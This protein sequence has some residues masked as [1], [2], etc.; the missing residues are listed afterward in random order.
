MTFYKPDRVVALL[1]ALAGALIMIYLLAYSGVP[2]TSD[3]LWLMDV[4]GN[5]ALHGQSILSRSLYLAYT[6]NRVPPFEPLQPFLSAPLYFLSYQLPHIGNLQTLFLFNPLIAALIALVVFL[7]ARLLGYEERTALVAAVLLGGTTIIWPYTQTFFREPLTALTLILTAFSL[8]HARKGFA[9]NRLRSLEWFLLGFVFI[10][11]SAL[12]KEAALILLPIFILILVP[13]GIFSNRKRMAVFIGAV[14]VLCLL[15][16]AVFVIS[17]DSAAEITRRYRIF[18]KVT[19]L[20]N[21]LA[22]NWQQIPIHLASILVSPGK[23]FFWFSPVLVLSLISPRWLPASRWRESWLWLLGTLWFALIYVVYKIDIWFGGQSWGP[24]FLVP[25]VPLLILATLPALDKLLNTRR[26]KWRIVLI[27]LVIIGVIVQIAGVY[28]SWGD[29]YGYQQKQTGLLPWSDQINWSFRWSQIWGGLLHIPQAKTTILW[30]QQPIQWDVIILLVAS[31][32][33][34]S[35]LAWILHLQQNHARREFILAGYAA[36]ILAILVTAFVMIRAYPT[37][38]YQGDNTA[39]HEMRSYLETNALSQDRLLLSNH[40]YAGF[41]MNYYK[42]PAYLF[43][44]PDSPGEQPSPEQLPQIVSGNPDYLVTDNFHTVLTD[45]QRGG[46]DYEG[47]LIWLVSDTGQYLPWAI[48]PYEWY[49]ARHFYPIGVKEVDPRT[50]VASFLSFAAPEPTEGAAHPIEAL[51]GKAIGL[52]GY[53]LSNKVGID[54]ASFRPGDQLGLSLLW[55]PVNKI[56]ADYTLAIHIINIQGQVVVQQDIQP[57][58]GN[59]PTSKWRVGEPFRTNVGFVLP[60]DLPPGEY[61]I[62]VT[63]YSWPS[64]ERLPVRS[65]AGEADHLILTTIIVR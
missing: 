51:F 25:V 36:P 52:K 30:L 33:I 57:E 7:Y 19:S 2:R 49:L 23:G 26:H 16:L 61:Q 34:F 41:F 64:L 65:A 14:I 37:P 12:T 11:L 15:L 1:L 55:N 38:R 39:L 42:G 58:N 21:R 9:Q 4:S 27:L 6:N 24:R 32:V 63:F 43:G 22:R 35:G 31:I 59:A 46:R 40:S 29:Y 47:G 48:R 8:E 54:P 5:I 45:I 18:D 56:D 28:E 60:Q 50:R 3:E 44:L 62:W 10:V 20:V 53:D 13:D 17:Q